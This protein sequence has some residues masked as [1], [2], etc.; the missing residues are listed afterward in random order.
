MVPSN[1]HEAIVVS[2][3]LI[4]SEFIRAHILGTIGVFIQSL[5]RKSTKF[6]E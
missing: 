4:L 1:S 3:L 5:S 2:T 6:Q